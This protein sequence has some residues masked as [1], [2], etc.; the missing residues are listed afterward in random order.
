MLKFKNIL[1]SFL[2]MVYAISFG[3]S[4]IPQHHHLNENGEHIEAVHCDA[5]HTSHSHIAHDNHVDEGI[6][7]FLGCLIENLHQELPADHHSCEMVSSSVEKSQVKR[8]SV[9]CQCDI[10]PNNHIQYENLHQVH[11]GFENL[12][13]I[14]NCYDGSTQFRRGPPQV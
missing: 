14:A 11:P 12:V 9:L 5:A 13:A 3:H 10:L 6:W 7:D 8:F 1:A 2:L 4:V